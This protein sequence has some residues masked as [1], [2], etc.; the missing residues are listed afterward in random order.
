MR[1]VLFVL[2]MSLVTQFIQAPSPASALSGRYVLATPFLGTYA[3]PVRVF[4]TTKELDVVTRMSSHLRLSQIRLKPAVNRGV[5]HIE[6]G[7]E[8]SEH[9]SMQR[10]VVRNLQQVLEKFNG[11]FAAWHIDVIV[12]RSQSYIKSQLAELGCAP[13]LS[14][15]G[16]EVLLGAAVCG[17]HVLISNLTGFLF[18]TA[19]DQPITSA[20]EQRREPRASSM[21]YQLEIRSLEGLAHEWAHSYRAAGQQGR[22]LVDEPAWVKEGLASMWASVSVVNTFQS[23][24]TYRDWH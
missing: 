15:T 8:K 18:L 1:R 19:P 5:W 24:M 11:T 16:G 9:L 10:Q 3:R 2:L 14:Q 23:R 13:D 4:L 21:P 20:M 6:P 17:R 12:G 22:V 7:L